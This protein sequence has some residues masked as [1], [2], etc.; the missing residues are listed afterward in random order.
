MTAIYR[1]NFIFIA[2]RYKEWQGGHCISSGDLDITI[3]AAVNGDEIHFELSDV[4]KLRILNSFDFEILDYHS[5]VLPDR[6]QYYHGTQDFRPI[7]PIICNIFYHH[8]DIDYVTFAMTNPNRIIEF[9]G[10]MDKL[11]QPYTGKKT[12]SIVPTLTAESILKELKSYGMVNIGAIMERAVNLYNSNCKVD[13]VEEGY[14]VIESLKLFAKVYE[15]ELQEME[16][17]ERDYSLSMPKILMFIALANYNIG[18]FNQAYCVAKQGID[19]ADN[20]EK[21][22]PIIGFTKSMYGTDKMEKII[23]QIENNFFDEV[24]DA[25]HY[26]DIEPNKV[27]T[28]KFKILAEKIKSTSINRDYILSTINFY[29]SVREELVSDYLQGNKFAFR[30]ISMLHEDVCPLFYAWEYFGYG[31]M[32][33]LWKEDLAIETYNNFKSRNVL[34]E[35]RKNL[36]ALNNGLFIFRVYDDDGKNLE[37]TKNILKALI[38]ALD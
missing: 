2:D 32:N 26:W 30:L 27:I 22:S 34:E 28:E 37:A 35:C 15:L 17:D 29:D 36:N 7:L 1:N 33:E 16:K 14:A 20:A 19:A 31:R 4:G 21:K 13:T 8:D 6:V 5:S 25:N 18:N 24:V 10:Y 9:Y 3:T 11:G 38:K 23:Q 12:Q